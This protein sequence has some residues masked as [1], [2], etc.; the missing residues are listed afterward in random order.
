MAKP[1][2]DHES[3]RRNAA[4]FGRSLSTYAETEAVAEF[5]RAVERC[6]AGSSA[7]AKALRMA[8]ARLRKTLR[9]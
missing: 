1:D 7:D 5:W 2:P 6:A 3:A 4:M 9:G 8:L